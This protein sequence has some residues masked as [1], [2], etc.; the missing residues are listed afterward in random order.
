MR[1]LAT[2]AVVGATLAG[3]GAGIWYAREPDAP[4]RPAA[5]NDELEG[6]VVEIFAL[7]ESADRASS[8][9]R[10]TR[11]HDARD[12]I[13]AASANHADDTRLHFLRGLVE[14]LA[15]RETETQTAYGRL[16]ALSS[17]G[18]R[19]PRALLL[20]SCRCWSSTPIGPRRRCGCCGPCGRRR[21]TT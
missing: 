5:V 16:V 13:A 21:R 19:D 18:E 3:V 2:A 11:L 8:A 10:T 6:P 20:R 1:A 17:A 9:S 12:R 15:H 7:I 14:V 4:A